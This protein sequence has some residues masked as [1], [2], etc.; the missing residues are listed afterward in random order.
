MGDGTSVLSYFLA[1][2]KIEEKV[3]WKMEIF[4]LFKKGYNYLTT[5]SLLELET[6]K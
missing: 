2:S 5:V 1:C 6:F 4:L 3:T